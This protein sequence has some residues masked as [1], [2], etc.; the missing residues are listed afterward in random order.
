[1]V[2]G[3]TQMRRIENETSRQVTFSKRRSG[4]LKK[5]FELSV[6]CDAEVGVIVFSPRGRLFEF[7]SS[8]MQRTIQ[9][10]KSHAKD[11]N[12]NKREAEDEIQ[13]QLWK[14]EA[15]TVTKEIQLLETTK[16]KLLGES[17]ETC[18]SNELHDLEFQLERSLINIRQWKERILTEQIVQ[19]KER[20]K[21]LMEE[22]VA[23]NRQWKGDSLQHSAVLEEATHDDNASQ[24]TEVETDL[25]I[26]LLGRRGTQC[27]LHA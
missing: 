27:L 13:V 15:A 8:S 3:K 5:A 18:S 20:E 23:L 10:Y 2:R 17:L 19:L 24:H 7:S 22:N 16:R 26:G 4:L 11:V 1:M 14:Q 9:R 21:L 6:L 12:L 25:C